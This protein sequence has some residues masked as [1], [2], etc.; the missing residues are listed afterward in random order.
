MDD[1]EYS[2]EEAIKRLEE[3][4]AYLEKDDVPLKD[5]LEKY[6]EGVN[7][8]KECRTTLSDVEKQIIVLSGEETT[9]V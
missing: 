6:T 7:L 4:S 5:A 2:I 9:D 1:K 8:I 3:I